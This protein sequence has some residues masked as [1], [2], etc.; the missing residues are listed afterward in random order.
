MNETKRIKNAV[1]YT[2]QSC[3]V[4]LISSCSSDKLQNLKAPYANWPCVICNTLS[5]VLMV[6]IGTQFKC[7]PAVAWGSLSYYVILEKI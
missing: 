4:S 5:T 2:V 6:I 1:C 3:F 7:I